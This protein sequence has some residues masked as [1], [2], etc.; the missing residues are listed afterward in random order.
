[1][2]RNGTQNELD[3]RAH[4]KWEHH[5]IADCRPSVPRD[6]FLTADILFSICVFVWAAVGG[7]LDI[8][9]IINVYTVCPK[10]IAIFSQISGI[11]TL[12][13][14]SFSDF[15]FVSVFSIFYQSARLPSYHHTSRCKLGNRIKSATLWFLLFT[16]QPPTS[17]QQP[18]PKR[19]CA[20]SSL[21]L[22]LPFCFFF[23][24]WW[25]S[26]ADSQTHTASSWFKWIIVCNFFLLPFSLFLFYA[27]TDNELANIRWF[28][29][30]R[31]WS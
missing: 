22:L 25:Y 8:P 12:V 15:N 11:N 21:M 3:H 17:N 5:V 18:Y 9:W 31:C 20:F 6:T 10:I 28:Q 16:K 7:P 26:Q 13:A 30:R 27:C 14:V 1:M 29:P 24:S 4:K 2:C 19:K 23:L